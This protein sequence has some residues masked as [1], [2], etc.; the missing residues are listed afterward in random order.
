MSKMRKY[1]GGVVL[2]LACAGL[3]YAPTASAAMPSVLTQQGRL[4]DDAGA[5]VDADVSFVFAIYAG[6]TGGTALWTETQTVTVDQGYFSARLGDVTALDPDLFDG[7]KTLYLG[8]KVGVDAEM[9]PRQ[10]ITSVPF[11]L[12][13]KD[14]DH[15][16]TA[17]LATMATN[18][19]TA[20]NATHAIAADSATNATN[21]TTAAAVTSIASN[22]SQAT[23]TGSATTSAVVAACPTG[24]KAIAG[25]CNATTGVMVSSFVKNQPTQYQCQCTA[26]CSVTTQVVCAK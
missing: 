16:A 6:A 7:S 9:T 18:A 24:Y 2:A 4:L 13:S 26:S 1:L 19:N 25:G 3:A 8:V 11:A 5:P 20:A 22:F 14:A 21:A 23:A 12:H 15:A 10:A 17:D